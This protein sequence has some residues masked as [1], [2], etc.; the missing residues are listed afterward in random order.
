MSTPTKP[1]PVP[2]ECQADTYQR[3]V[4]MH[5]DDLLRIRILGPVRVIR[6][7]D[8]VTMDFRSNRLNISLDA[9]GRVTRV[10]CG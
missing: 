1:R 7:G 6:P 8:I 10:Y 2:A 4:G 3:L 9:N 5:H